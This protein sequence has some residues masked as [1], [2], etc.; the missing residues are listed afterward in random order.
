MA[1]SKKML[2]FKSIEL[3]ALVVMLVGLREAHGHAILDAIAD[4]GANV[5][6]V[7]DLDHLFKQYDERRLVDS[8][9]DDQPLDY[10][11]DDLAESYHRFVDKRRQLDS[12]G[13]ISSELSASRAAN[14]HHNGGRM[15]RHRGSGKQTNAKRGGE[16]KLTRNDGR[17]SIPCL[18]NSIS[19]HML[20]KK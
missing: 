8:Y 15:I 5:G 9:L 7:N 20:G 19:C 11:D 6:E 3:V 14:H 12:A 17:Y 1:L 16:I 10:Y 2:L 4:N 18:L 13:A